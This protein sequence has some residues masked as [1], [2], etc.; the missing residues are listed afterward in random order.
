MRHPQADSSAGTGQQIPV[1]PNSP[2]AFLCGLVA[3]GYVGGHIVPLPKLT[4]TIRSCDRRKRSEGA[5]CRNEDLF[6]RADRRAN[7]GIR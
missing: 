3:G 2:C 6:G 1:S 4:G 7:N 5:H